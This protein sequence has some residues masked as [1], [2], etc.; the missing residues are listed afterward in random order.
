MSC[1]PSIPL[2]ITSTIIN[3]SSLFLPVKSYDGIEKVLGS[4]QGDR[5]DYIFISMND[6]DITLLLGRYELP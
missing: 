5:Y 2:E 1:N 4:I 3:C 6:K